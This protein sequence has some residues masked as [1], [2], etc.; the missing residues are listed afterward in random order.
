MAVVERTEPAPPAPPH[1]GRRLVLI[2]L[3]CLILGA[4]GGVLAA[5]TTRT[6]PAAARFVPPREVAFDFSLRNHDGVR[7]SLAD[8]RGKVIALTFIYSYCRDLCPAEGAA[9]AQA[10]RDVGGDDVVAYIVSVDPIGDTPKRAKAWL[11]RRGFAG[12]GQYLV[13]SRDELRPVWIHYGIAPVNASRQES[14]AASGRGR[15]L[16]RGQ[17]EHREA[18][19]QVRAATTT[20]RRAGGGLGLLPGPGRSRLPRPGPPHRGLG[21]RALGVRDADRQTRPA[22]ARH[23]VRVARFSDAGAGLSR[24]ALRARLGVL[25]R[26]RGCSDL[27][28]SRLVTPGSALDRA[29]HRWAPWCCAARLG[30]RTAGWRDPMEELSS[31][32][33]GKSGRSPTRSWG[34]FWPRGWYPRGG[35]QSH[36]RSR[37]WHRF[38]VG[39]ALMCTRAALVR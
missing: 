8:A 1:P 17:P 3:M 15:R 33:A 25:M 36:R 6:E 12:R 2:A 11:E 22:T 28:G 27:R 30:T 37:P 18:P 24:T 13:G 29:W 4:L 34:M 23:P 21:L 20:E 16:S 7:T 9:I 38:A 10:M 26:W 5:T 35:P 19:V 32:V 14:L 31:G 39:L